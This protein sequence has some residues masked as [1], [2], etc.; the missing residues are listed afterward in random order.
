MQVPA[1]KLAKR[2]KYHRQ[3]PESDLRVVVGSIDPIDPFPTHPIEV[4]SAKTLPGSRGGGLNAHLIIALRRLLPREARFEL[5]RDRRESPS[6]PASGTKHPP[7]QGQLPRCRP[8][9][10]R[11]GEPANRSPHG[12][13]LPLMTS[14]APYFFSSFTLASAEC[15]SLTSN[16]PN[17]AAQTHTPL[18][19]YSLA[20]SRSSSSNP[21]DYLSAYDDWRLAWAFSAAGVRTCLSPSDFH[22]P[23]VGP[24][25]PARGLPLLLVGHRRSLCTPRAVCRVPCAAALLVASGCCWIWLPWPSQ[26]GPQP[27]EPSG[28]ASE[29]PPRCVRVGWCALRSHNPGAC[30]SSRNVQALVRPPRGRLWTN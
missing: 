13:P 29:E 20:R 17:P 14:E 16:T 7:P 23:K 1:G 18:G 10:A 30:G 25:R 19:S 8:E 26:S 5:D 28:R 12:P 27:A 22:L 9:I 21:G 3:A 6:E 24:T 4:L 11:G 2:V 15:R